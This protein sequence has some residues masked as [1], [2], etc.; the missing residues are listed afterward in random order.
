MSDDDVTAT[1]DSERPNHE[2]VRPEE[3]GDTHHLFLGKRWGNHAEEN[4]EKWGNQEPKVLLLAMAEELAEIADEL[5]EDN[6]LPP[7][8]YRN[9]ADR[10][11]NDIRTDG[12][13]AREYLEG[14]CEDDD[15]SPLPMDERPV[16]DGVS[17]PERAASETEDLA[18]LVYQLYWSLE[19]RSLDTDTEHSE[20]SQ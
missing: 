3:D 6:G 14:H 13:R 5:L 12:Y 10:I 9:D 19:D 8:A 20:G 15:G 17:Q 18:P 11:L 1:T 16:H 7:N 2:G 4:I